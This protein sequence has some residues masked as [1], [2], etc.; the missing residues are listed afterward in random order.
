M[1]VFKC[2][3]CG[4]DVEVSQNIT[5]GTCAFC[6][7]TMTLPKNSDD[8][9]ANLFN[10]AN[11]FRRL[12]EF[13]KAIAAYEN[14]LNEDYQNSEAH[15]GVVLSRFG[16]EYIE[17]PV[18][19]KRVP[20]CRRMQYESFLNDPDYQ[21]A[22]QFAPDDLTRA[23]YLQEAMTISEIQK[24]ILAIS[25]KEEKFDIFICYKENTDN[26]TRTPDSV[27]AQDLY[28]LLTAEGFK[29]FYAKITLEQKLGQAFEP[30]IFSA[31]HSAKVM[32]L[33]GTKAEYFN[34]VWVKNEWSRFLSIM[35]E[36][37]NRLLIPCYR[38]MDPYD[39]PESISALQAQDMSK[40]GFSQDLIRGIKK[41]V[42]ENKV[43][44]E[45]NQHVTSAI[46]AP[47]VG[48][49]LKRAHL[50]LEDGDFKSADDYFNRVLDIDP[51]CS[52]AYLGRF[53]A[54]IKAKSIDALISTT[55]MEVLDQSGNFQKALRFANVE[56]KSN[57]TSIKS[58]IRE[59]V[60]SEEAR[61]KALTENSTLIVEN[62]I[63]NCNSFQRLSTKGLNI[64]IGD[65]YGGGIVFYLFQEGDIGYD[66]EEVHGLIASLNNL[67]TGVVWSKVNNHKE[68]I[69]GTDSEVGSGYANTALIVNQN[70][71]DNSYAGG[72]T[73]GYE[74]GGFTD[75]YLPSLD[76]L[77][78]LYEKKDLLE[79]CSG[80]Y[81][82]S[83]ERFD[84]FVWVI[85]FDTGS[86]LD[87]YKSA[88]NK[89]RAIRS[90]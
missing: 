40:I 39:L 63:K 90:F 36:D 21:A 15:F 20:T 65:R 88:K 76:E 34:A 82:S 64:K 26:G 32:I 1:I 22:L 57:L 41:V 69:E 35:K 8:R 28:Y 17:D 85:D 72:V 87:D 75:W 13:D 70:K 14:I 44:S 12:N 51:E 54:E 56:E 3:M 84:N 47:N 33:I 81:W 29:V 67:S 10:R 31:L 50:F 58:K 71:Q 77:G 73:F 80:I 52:N 18:T 30:Y 89:V 7:S 78:L 79:D 25:N 24:G 11:H 6:G 2:K 61:M 4:G 42:F 19:H 43:H 9:I 53:M 49:L 45:Q 60:E 38:D 68:M 5:I 62:K 66:S 46:N 23:L 74:G 37:R 86:H 16:I 48:S 27:I 59:R 55:T 83:T